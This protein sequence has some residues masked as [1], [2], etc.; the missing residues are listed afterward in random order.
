MSTF[1]HNQ[2]L[3]LKN[4]WNNFHPFIQI[5]PLFELFGLVYFGGHYLVS[6]HMVSHTCFIILSIRLLI[7]K[8]TDSSFIVFI[9]CQC[10][11]VYAQEFEGGGK[12]VWENI[13][14]F[15]FVCIF[16]SEIVFFAYMGIKEGQIQAI[17]GIIALVGTIVV[18]SRLNRN[19]IRPL[20]NLAMSVAA[21]VDIDDG[22]MDLLKD[23]STLAFRDAV[24]E[25]LYGQ[26][27]LKMSK[28]EREPL[29]YRREL[30][31]V[32]NDTVDSFK[33]HS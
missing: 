33:E 23:I 12:S 21:D 20:Q 17:L 13:S 19:I 10:L 9:L 22:E 30:N 16:M 24:E 2:S 25:Q 15:M 1:P 32:E 29:P 8:K 31:D 27:S 18:K 28:D 5:T 7:K 6:S 14:A 3:T 11:H 4:F 26:P